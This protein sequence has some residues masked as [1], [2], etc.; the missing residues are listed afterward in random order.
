MGR[1]CVCLRG[2]KPQPPTWSSSFC[3]FCPVVF[4][5]HRNCSSFK[6]WITLLAPPPSGLAPHVK[7]MPHIKHST[8]VLPLI[9]VCVLGER[10]SCWC[11]VC[12][13]SACHVLFPD[14]MPSRIGTNVT[15]QRSFLS[16]FLA[17][18]VWK[19]S[20]PLLHA[21]FHLFFLKE[22]FPPKGLFPLR[23][24]F[25]IW[26]HLAALSSFYADCEQFVV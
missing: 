25:M 7:Q 4:P 5:S 26:L 15:F 10:C 2:G 22:S 11:C 17:H 9:S 3:N 13:P 18:F 24:Q 20:S 12:L 23:L 14:L 21:H 8:V 6:M 16:L 1:R 19:C